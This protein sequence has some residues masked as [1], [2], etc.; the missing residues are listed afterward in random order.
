[1][2]QSIERAAVG[3]GAIAGCVRAVL[4]SRAAGARSA[5]AWFTGGRAARISRRSSSSFSR[6]SRRGRSRRSSSEG[7]IPPRP[8][9]R[10]RST[11]FSTRALAPDLRPRIR[12][13]RQ[14]PGVA[15]FFSAAVGGSAC[16][17][18][19]LF[20]RWMVRSDAVDF[21]VWTNGAGV[22]AHRAARHSRHPRG[23]LPGIDA[24]HEPWLEDGGRHHG[25]AAPAGCGSIR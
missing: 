5:A 21:G 14:R 4:R 6:C 23:T 8:I 19:N 3:D 2:L 24:L 22:E 7:T 1:M 10:R 20:L 25:I 17:R 18:L 12:H 13:R 9:C 16:K 11:R 15:Y